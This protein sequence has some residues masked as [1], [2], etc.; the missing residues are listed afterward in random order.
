MP[1]E[2]RRGAQ[3]LRLSKPI[4][5]TMRSQNALVLDIGMNGAFVEHYGTVQPGERFR[6]AFRW[7]SEDVEFLC[8]VTRSN[9]VQTPGGDGASPVSHSGLRFVEAVG[10][11]GR[12]LHDLM[13]TFITR[14]LDAQ[15]A[16]AAGESHAAGANILARLGE[17]R[18]TRSRGYF[19]YRW[20]GERWSRTRTTSRVQPVDG[21]TV[22]EH[23]DE[24]E[25]E[26]LCRTYESSDAE[27][28]D[29][30]RVLADLTVAE[31]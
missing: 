24:E 20:N 19:A 11:S 29:L 14:V 9:V 21:F 5:A 27:S 18:R 10:E 12:R 13:T 3:R 26:S 6:L 8:E 28:R 23:E 25:V 1:P 17:A 30:I 7:Q 31:R 4:L 16:N 15:K 2:E 22:P